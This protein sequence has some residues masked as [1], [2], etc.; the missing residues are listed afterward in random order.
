MA[1]RT[2]RPVLRRCA[3]CGEQSHKGQLVRIVRTP[4]GKVHVDPTGK[5][6]GRGAYLCANPQC[7]DRGIAKNRLDNVL[8]STIDKEDKESLQSYFRKRNELALAGS[9]Q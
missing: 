6:S 7:W 5:V 1:A 2:K 8:R 3:A 4:Q 9:T